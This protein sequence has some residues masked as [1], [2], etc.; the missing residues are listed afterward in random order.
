MDLTKKS[1]L[2]WNVENAN[3]RIHNGDPTS[4]L[5]EKQINEFL[6]IWVHRKPRSLVMKKKLRLKARLDF[7]LAYTFSNSE[8]FKQ[9]MAKGDISNLHTGYT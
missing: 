3:I 9:I 2:G 4:I 6:K 1:L 7:D 8:I 5:N